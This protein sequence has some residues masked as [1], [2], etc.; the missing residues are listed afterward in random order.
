MMIPYLNFFLSS[1]SFERWDV[2]K[3]DVFRLDL[4]ALV[5]F[6]KQGVRV[7]IV[8]CCT[9]IRENQFS[10]GEYLLWGGER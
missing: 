4:Y 8:V 5:L 7:Q 3:L 6:F 10:A 9:T 2:V 1:V